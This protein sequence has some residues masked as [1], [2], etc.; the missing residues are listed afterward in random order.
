MVAPPSSKSM[1]NRLIPGDTGFQLDDKNKTSEVFSHQYE[2][3][4]LI[5]SCSHQTQTLVDIVY[6]YMFD[7]NAIF[8][9]GHYEYSKVELIILVSLTKL[10]CSY[11]MNVL[12]MTPVNI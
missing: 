1:H 8:T 6:G 2:S 12:S 7:S 10:N 9:C 5:S 11:N 3:S 4:F